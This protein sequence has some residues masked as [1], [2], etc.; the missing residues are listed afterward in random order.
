MVMSDT[1]RRERIASIKDLPAKLEGLVS[2]LS[3]EQ[4]DR[5]AGGEGWSIRQVVHHLA[6]AHLNAFLRTKLILTESKPILKP[7]DQEAWAELP[8]TTALPMEPSLQMVKGIHARWSVLLESLPESSWEK[9]GVHLENGLMT[10]DDILKTYA[11]HGQT[12]LDQIGRI[13]A[14]LGE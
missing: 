9:A 12:H 3:E 4:L 2:G 14:G 1:E 7:F 11:G 6:D 8:D 5:H 10:L 13:K